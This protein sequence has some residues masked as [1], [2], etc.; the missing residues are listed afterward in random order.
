MIRL[1]IEGQEADTT[2][3]FSHQITYAVDDLNNLDSKATAFS[4][5]IVLPGTAKNNSLLGNIF[6][7][8]NSNFTGEGENVYYNFNASRSAKCRLDSNGLTIIKGSLRLLEIVRDGDS[9]EYE[10]AIFGELGSFVSKLSNKKLEDLDFGIYNHTYNIST[11]DDYW[12][13]TNDYAFYTDIETTLVNGT[14]AYID[15][16][17]NVTDYI[18]VGDVIEPIRQSNNTSYGQRTADSVTWDG[19]KTTIEVSANWSPTPST[20]FSCKIIVKNKKGFG[21]YYPLIDYGNY[22]TDKIDYKLKT[23]RPALHVFEYIDKIIK[24]AGYTWESKFFQTDFFKRLI[25]P[26]NESILNTLKQDLFS[27]NFISKNLDNIN[28]SS[29][30]INLRLNEIY[31]DLFDTTDNETFT[32]TGQNTTVNIKGDIKLPYTKNFYSNY[33]RGKVELFKNGTCVRVDAYP[34][35]GYGSNY[36]NF[37]FVVNETITLNTNDYIEFKISVQEG[38]GYFYFVFNQILTDLGNI[39]IASLYPISAPVNYNDLVQMN[40]SIPKNY[41]QK[42]FFSSILKMFYLMVTEDKYKDRHLKIEP[43]T[44]FY[45]LNK[46]SYVDWTMK[47][48]RSQPIRIKP[49]SEANAR[50]YDIKYKSDNDYYNEFYRKRYNEGYGDVRFDNQL[51]FSK[52]A[53]TTEVIFSATPL[54]GYNNID[55]IVPAIMKWDGKDAG[56]NEETINSNIRIMQ[57]KGIEGVDEWSVLNDTGGIYAS[58][59]KYPYAGHF[60]D[61]DAPGS[62]IN[63]GATKELFF[64]LSAGALGNN[65]FNTFYS[66]YLAEITDKDSRLVTAKFKLNDTDIFNLDFGKFIFLD[67]VLYRLSRIM[68]Y[69]P[70]ELCTV[71]LLRVIYTTY[72]SSVNASDV[73]EVFIGGHVWQTK[74]YDGT[75]Y[76]NGDEIPEITNAVDWENATEGAWCY[77]G[78]RSEN[79]VKYGKLYNWFAI[80]DPRGFAPLGYHVPTVDEFADLGDAVGGSA[81]ALKAIGTDYWNTANG[82]DTEQFSARGAGERDE[83]G[84][85]DYL[86]SRA[87]FWTSEEYDDDLAFEVGIDNASDTIQGD[88]TDKNYGYS[89]RLIKD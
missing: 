7:F 22:S 44:W 55:K 35:E 73:P 1:F 89:V 21:I 36:F 46:S 66:S 62:D 49:M 25:I 75:K 71:E 85:F 72:D 24:G 2:Q 70:G 52:D 77:Y 37:N 64:S 86:K 20:S 53:S 19:T 26:H 76:R 81:Y 33:L 40:L 5:T 51:E 84:Q 60:D 4:K 48:D 13:D 42:D 87:R 10:V 12:S 61:P 43:F 39:K 67:G 59:T 18:E 15:I 9:I 50:Y 68:D 16:Y 74:N 30:Y 32:Y 58:Y 69:T 29:G 14:P 80:N 65:L 54:V 83:Y 45:D 78:N 63:F 27:G 3:G 38:N 28:S 88:K 47:L 56:I 34:F 17:Q 8:S 82:T 79:G 23:F 6:E 57:K 31:G 11:I 41:L